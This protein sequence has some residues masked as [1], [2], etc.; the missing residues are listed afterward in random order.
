MWLLWNCRIKIQRGNRT[1]RC[2]PCNSEGSLQCSRDEEVFNEDCTTWRQ[3]SGGDGITTWYPVVRRG[4][5]DIRT[6]VQMTLWSRMVSFLQCRLILIAERWGGLQ[7]GVHNGDCRAEVR[8]TLVVPRV[9]EIRPDK[10]QAVSTQWDVVLMGR[11]WLN[12]QHFT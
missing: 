4:P 11:C 10:V 5:L 8:W 12:Q 9:E 6:K 1:G 3:S 7:W 2:S